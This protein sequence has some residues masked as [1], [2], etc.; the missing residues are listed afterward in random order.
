MSLSIQGKVV[1]RQKALLSYANNN[2]CHKNIKPYITNLIGSI[3]YMISEKIYRL[4]KK[5]F[6]IMPGKGV[7]IY[8]SK[9]YKISIIHVLQQSCSKL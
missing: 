4:R 5:I 2:K 6:Q 7:N 3:T 9:L 8:K 1:Y